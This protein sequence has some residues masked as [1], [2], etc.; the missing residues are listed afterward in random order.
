MNSLIRVIGLAPSELTFP[1]FLDRLKK[2]KERVAKIIEEMRKTPLKKKTGVIRT[3]T[4]GAKKL[5]KA[6][7]MHEEI[8]QQELARVAEELGVSSIEELKKLLKGD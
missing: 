1:I 2:E 5:T 6:A 3:G 7:L 8:K 4:T